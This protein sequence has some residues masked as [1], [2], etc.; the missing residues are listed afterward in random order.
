MAA[1]ELQ[2]VSAEKDILEEKELTSEEKQKVD[3]I[4]KEVDLSDSQAIIQFGVSAQSG[5]SSFSD[6]ILNDIRSKDAGHAGEALADLMMNVKSLRVDSL[7]GDG[8]LSNI[9]ILGNLMNSVKKFISQYEKVAVHIDR[10]TDELTKERMQ[11][12]KDITMLDTMYEKNNDF[13]RNLDLYIYAGKKKLDEVENDLIPKLRSEAEAS[14]DAVDA[15][16]VQ[17]MIQMASRLDKKIYDLQLSRMISIQTS[18]Q[19]RLIQSNDQ[20]LVEKIQSSILNTIPLWKNQ[21]IIAISMFRQKKALKLQK[22]VTDTTNDLLAKNSELLK[23]NSIG[24]AKE[25]E[26]GIVEL[27]TLKKVHSDLLTTLEETLKIQAEG[28]QKRA[29]AEV[30]IQKLESDLKAKLTQVKSEGAANL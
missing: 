22:E 4:L 30:E 23:E 29:A 18:P 2:K 10:I 16:K 6:T 9:P 5:I 21:V 14:G 1:M 19:L 24:V 20:V 28:K 7:S 12:L 13:L 25:A 8:F 26:R 15:Q 17:D 3:A 11:L 27:E